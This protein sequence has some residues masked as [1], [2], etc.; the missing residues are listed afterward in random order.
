MAIWR[1]LE[2]HFPEKALLGRDAKEIALVAMWERRMDL[3]GFTPAMEAARNRAP[4]LVGRALPGPHAYDQ[5][6]ALADRSLKRIDNFY[7]DLEEHLQASPFVVG[8]TFTVADITAFA[9]VDFA[10]AIG[11]PL[12]ATHTAIRRWYDVVA[13]RP[14]S[15][16]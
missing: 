8:D 14:S 16:A 3:N 1:Y 4:G 6:P 15:L 10:T 12:P 7:D 11:K 13:S 5:I 9:T 2:E